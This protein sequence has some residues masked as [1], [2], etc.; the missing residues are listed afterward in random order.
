MMTLMGARRLSAERA[1]LASASLCMRRRR[2]NSLRCAASRSFCSSSACM[3]SSSSFLSLFSSS[4]LARSMP[5][6][7]NFSWSRFFSN[8][9]RS[10][11]SSA[12]CSLRTSRL[13]V[14]A[15]RLASQSLSASQSS[16]T[17]GAASTTAA[18]GSGLVS[19]STLGLLLFF[20]GLVFLYRSE[21]FTGAAGVVLSTVGRATPAAFSA[22]KRAW[23][24]FCFSF[25]ALVMKV[26]AATWASFFSSLAL[27][28]R[29]FSSAAAFSSAAIFSSSRRTRSSS[30]SCN[31]LIRAS[32]SSWA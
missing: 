5:R 32:S 8:S 7:F 24:F 31:F 11:T 12:T 14:M 18:T 25:S 21:A 27:R 1:A 23:I 6:C 22:S 2:A 10:S 15:S 20:A 3:R 19:S 29:S 13:M 28:R 30:A 9:I 16:A 17:S 26:P 4:L